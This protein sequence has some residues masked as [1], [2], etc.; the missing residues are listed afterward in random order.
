[1]LRDQFDVFMSL[2][3]VYVFFIEY[4]QVYY[5]VRTQGMTASSAKSQ[6]WLPVCKLT[7]TRNCTLREQGRFNLLVL[8]AH[9]HTHTHTH[10]RTHRRSEWG[11]L[12]AFISKAH[13]SHTSKRSTDLRLTTTHNLET[14]YLRSH[15]HRERDT[16]THPHTSE[17]CLKLSLIT[18]NMILAVRHWTQTT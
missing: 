5:D 6:G 2:L 3:C 1:M 18:L 13:S 14:H 7:H 4:M 8:N 16:H 9:T 11:L 15:K 17:E 10:R 12:N